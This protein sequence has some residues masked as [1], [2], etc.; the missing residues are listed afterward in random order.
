MGK[1]MA[2]AVKRAWENLGHKL[3]RQNDALFLLHKGN[4]QEVKILRK[5]ILQGVEK[6][7]EYPKGYKLC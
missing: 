6:C 1:T 7:S 2:N 4:Q 3:V 5:L